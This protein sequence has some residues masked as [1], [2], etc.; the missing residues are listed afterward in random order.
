M[1]REVQDCVAPES[2]QAA[3]ELALVLP[4]LMIIAVAVCQV[5][6]ALNC[7]LVITSASRD[8][9]RRGA[10][11]NDRNAATKAALASAKGLPGEGPEV[12]V[13]FPEGRS[14]GSPVA[15]TITY[16]MPLLLPGLDK[17]LSRPVFKTSASMALE[18][19]P[20]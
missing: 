17:L 8:G 7:Y 19:G 14:K 9:A 2:G 5:A 15:V 16:H 3:V 4:V 11:T 20:E 18:R 10:E 13:S 1:S 6:L 12:N